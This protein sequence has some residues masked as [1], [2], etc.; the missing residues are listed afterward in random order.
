[1][2]RYAWETACCLSGGP[3]TV[4]ERCRRPGRGSPG[5]QPTLLPGAFLWPSSC[6]SCATTTGLGGR[7]PSTKA[8]VALHQRRSNNTSKQRKQQPTIVVGT[9]QPV[10]L[11][12]GRSTALRPSVVAREAVQVGS[13]N[14]TASHLGGCLSASCG[15]STVCCLGRANQYTVAA[16][17]RPLQYQAYCIRRPAEAGMMIPQTNKGT[18]GLLTLSKVSRP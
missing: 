15:L 12:G 3:P 5:S 14:L 8:P 11:R 4:I 16:D 10:R 1:M 9:I 17:D 7:P 6:D 2:S 18:G 13:E